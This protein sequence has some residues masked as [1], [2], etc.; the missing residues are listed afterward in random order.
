MS[1]ARRHV[2]RWFL[3][4]AGTWAAA[5]T[6]IAFAYPIPLGPP[7]GE[8]SVDINGH[9][10]T[11]NPP[12]PTLFDRDAYSIKLALVVVGLAFAAA[13]I[14]NSIL[15]ER[16]ESRF[17]RVTVVAGGFLIAYS[18]FGLGWGLLSVGVVGLLL[19]LAGQLWD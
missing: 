13:L 15:A 8:T 11:G 14:E 9:T 18:L 19:V 4:A 10:Y 12:A 17:G 2:R 5:W 16:G 3:L 7:G 6:A 1:I